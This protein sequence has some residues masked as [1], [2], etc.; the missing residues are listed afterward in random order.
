M[1]SGRW[2]AKRQPVTKKMSDSRTLSGSNAEQA[3][4]IM[5]ELGA[6]EAYIYAMGEETWLVG[7]VMATRATVGPDESPVLGLGP[8]GVLPSHQRQGVGTVL[9]E[10][11][12]G[13]V[14][15]LDEP[16]IVLLGEPAYYHRFGFE[17]AATFGIEPPDPA[18][19]PNFLVRPSHTYDPAVRGL[20]IYAEPFSH[21]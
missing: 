5:T 2:P 16:M 7:H 9:M 12:I 6:N 11:I 15:S 1:S 19:A 20:F 8:L 3:A 18:W 14:E 4:D 17:L 21:L 10:T 13:I